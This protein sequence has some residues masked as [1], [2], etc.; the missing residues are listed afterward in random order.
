M[1]LTMETGCPANVRLTGH[2]QSLGEA[3]AA[4]GSRLIEET[5]AQLEGGGQP[6]ELICHG[7]NPRSLLL[8]WVEL[9]LYAMDARQAIFRDLEVS[10]QDGKHLRARAVAVPLAGRRRA[11]PR[12]VEAQSSKVVQGGPGDWDAECQVTLGQEA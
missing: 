4:L 9:L 5:G 12:S 7:P 1:D 2:G 6:I 10:V 8:S 11:W 3:L